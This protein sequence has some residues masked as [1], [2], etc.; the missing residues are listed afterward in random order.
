MCWYRDYYCKYIECCCRCQSRHVLGGTCKQ[1]HARILLVFPGFHGRAKSKFQ[2]HWTS[3]VINFVRC[4]SPEF[5]SPQCIYNYMKVSA[6]MHCDIC[7]TLGFFVDGIPAST[8]PL[9]FPS[10]L[11]PDFDHISY[12]AFEMLEYPSLFSETYI[13]RWGCWRGKLKG[14][15]INIFPGQVQEDMKKTSDSVQWVQCGMLD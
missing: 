7:G 8:D 13:C 12:I 3:E 9:E 14:N 2:W 4:C 11:F 5:R 10:R 6:A 15:P 1:P